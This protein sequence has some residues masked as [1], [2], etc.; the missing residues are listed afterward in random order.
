MYHYMQQLFISLNSHFLF[1]CRD[2]L[3][4]MFNCPPPPPYGPALLLGICV[5]F[6]FYPWFSS[7]F[8]VC[9]PLVKYLT[10]SWHFPFICKKVSDSHPEV[11][12]TSVLRLR[13]CTW[14]KVWGNYNWLSVIF[15]LTSNLSLKAWLLRRASSASARSRRLL[16]AMAPPLGRYICCVSARSCPTYL[17]L[18]HQKHIWIYLSRTFL[19]IAPAMF[20]PWVRKILWRRELQ[21][22]PMFLPGEFHGQRSLAGYS[23]WGH[24][25]LDTTEQKN[26]FYFLS[27]FKVYY[28]FRHTE[29]AR[30]V[31]RFFTH[32]PQMLTFTTFV[33]CMY[34]HTDTYA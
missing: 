1:P 16:F 11:V 10:L 19:Q 9:V 13:E 2:W 24:I 30:T 12:P 6:R 5:V 23:L 3:G 7:L 20:D 22:T 31:Q 28:H 29:V 33:L 15:Q 8:V 21:P 26:T 18:R 32:I 17:L 14:R 25:E 4:A 34:I 27:T